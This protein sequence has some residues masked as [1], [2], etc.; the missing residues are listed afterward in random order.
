VTSH[1]VVS[2]H[3][4]D[5][6]WSAGG[7]IALWRAAG[8]RVTV[9]TVFDGD[10]EADSA[11]GWRTIAD[12]RT[13][14]A[15]DMAALAGLGVRRVSVGWP[16]AALRTDNGNPRYPGQLRL[17]SRPHETD[18]A[19]SALLTELLR[20]MCGP[21]VVLHGPLAA[22]RHVDHVLVRD[23]VDLLAAT[24]QAQRYYEDFPYRLRPPDHT[25]LVA[26]YEPVDTVAWLRAALRYGSQVSAMFESGERFERTLFERARAHGR[27]AGMA[28]ADRV[29]AAEGT[30]FEL[31]A[32]ATEMLVKPIL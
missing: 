27:A 21:D 32:E 10:G 11:A 8:Q 13:R 18:I 4:D 15:E 6:V 20:D 23:A 30:G 14:R 17:F 3:P 24:G 5:A 29:W 12:A 31:T 22:G 28:Y 16:E 1:V 9:V 7:R 2:P 25:G 19:F 26:A